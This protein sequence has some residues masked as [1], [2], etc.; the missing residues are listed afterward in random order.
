MIHRIIQNQVVKALKPAK[1]V[2]IFGPRRSGK[3][4]LMNQIKA[5]IIGKVLVLHGENLDA[6][7]AM[8]SQ[9]T[10]V[11]EQLVAGYDYLFIDE[12]QRI[13]NIGV[14]LKLMVDTVPNVS[15]L[16]SGSSA[17][18]LKNKIG[19]PLVGRSHYFYLY[20]LSQLEINPDRNYLT[21]QSN[22]E[23]D[24]IFG[25]YPQVMTTESAEKKIEQL[26][27]IR[28]GYLLR[29]ILEMDNLKDSLFIL[30]LLR[31]IAFQ[32][33][34]DISYSELAT[35]LNA[36][37]KTV[38]RYLE[39][40]EKSYVLFSLP[41]FSR[42]LRKEYT[43]TPR[44]YFWDNGMRNA[45]INN[46][47]NLNSRDDIGRLW[48]NY[49]ISER[50]KMAEYTELYA[51]RYFWR[52]YDQKEIDLIEERGGKLFGYEFK[53]R[54]DKAKVPQEFL[55]TYPGSEFSVV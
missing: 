4:T 35:N 8:S 38:H 50:M 26:E 44:Y 20:P 34:N 24:L 10:S 25:S 48:E 29:D 27:S 53:W 16:V 1:V 11:L 17:F 5:E 13:P 14:N 18:D 47:N 31:L 36:S 32:I 12:A 23:R 55:N 43:K 30:N 15:I 2:G 49:C 45:I 7:E 21:A 39:M 3:T 6:A 33:G 40:L 28:N 9:R 22:L 54:E 37:G 41:G 46:F 51:N 42:N 52:T 19:E